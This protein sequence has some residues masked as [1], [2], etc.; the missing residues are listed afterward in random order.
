MREN[1][2]TL[3]SQI[4]QKSKYEKILKSFLK[5]ILKTLASRL[6]VWLANMED[7]KG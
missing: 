2:E 6:V 5:K 1:K 4:Y 3:W 7:D